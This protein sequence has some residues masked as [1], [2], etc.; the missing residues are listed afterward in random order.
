MTIMFTPNSWF[1]GLE[2]ADPSYLLL[3]TLPRLRKQR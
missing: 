3:A 2:R 1:A